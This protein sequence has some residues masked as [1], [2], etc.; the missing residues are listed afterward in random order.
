VHSYHAEVAAAGGG[1]FGV[2][3]KLATAVKK[4]FK[5]SRGSMNFFPENFLHEKQCIS[6]N[7]YAWI[8]I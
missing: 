6:C 7:Y 2:P 4:A 8:Y 3:N 1:L 5:E